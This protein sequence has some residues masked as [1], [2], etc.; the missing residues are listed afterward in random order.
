MAYWSLFLSS[1]ISATLFPLNSEVVFIALLYKD[2]SVVLLLLVATMGNTLGSYTTYGVGR[3]GSV[4]WLKRFGY[5]DNKASRYKLLIERH[6][7]WLGFLAW[8]PVVG[9]VFVLF[10][11]FFKVPFLPSALTILVGKAVRYVAIYL[12]IDKM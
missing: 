9:D 1:F 8:V 4:K 12:L 2:Y 6:G 5:N 11:G 3:M 7:F 10:L